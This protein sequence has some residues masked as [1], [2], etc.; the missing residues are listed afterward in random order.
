L[1]DKMPRLAVI[2]AEGA[3]PFYEFV[4]NGGEFQAV[5]N[6]ET[7]ATAIRIGDPVSWPKALHE[8]RSTNGVV[9][10]VSEQEIADAKAQI[11]RCGHRMRAGIGRDARRDSQADGERHHRPERGRG[12]RAHREPVEGPRLHLSLSHRKTGGS[13]RSRDTFPVCQ[14]ARSVTQR[15]RPDR[16]ILAGLKT[17]PR[18]HVPLNGGG[19]IR[20]RMGVLKGSS[21]FGTKER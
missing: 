10:K 6:P 14:S 17:L 16:R 1:I 19:V 3:A 12:R 18:T 20:S 4:Q 8:I 2:Q 13:G 9:E 7:L 11:G 5:T 21:T 15:R